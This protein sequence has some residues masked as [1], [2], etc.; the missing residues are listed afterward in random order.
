MRGL[1]IHIP[2]CKHICLYCD[3]RKTV[4]LKREIM[5]KYIKYL[6]N[7][8][9]SYKDKYKDCNTIYIG[10]GTPNA[11]PLDLLKSLFNTIDIFKEKLN[12]KEY[13]IEINPELL[14]IDQVNLFKKHNIT[15]V[16]IGAESFNDEILKKLGRHHCKEDIFNSVNLLKS[17]GINNINVDLIFAHP[18]DNLDLVKENLN[19]F[20]LLDIPH[21][22]YYSMI[23][24]DK[25][26]F[27]YQYD[28]NEIEMPSEDLSADLF[29]FIINDL[30]DHN[31]KQYEISNFSKEGFESI[32][33]EIYWKDLEYIGCGLNASGYLDNIRYTNSPN[34]KEYYLGKKETEVIDEETNRNEYMMLGLRMVKGVSINEYHQRFNR[35][36]LDDYSLDKFINDGLLEKVDGYIRFTRKG[37]ML[38][39][40][41]FMEFV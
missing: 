3:F 39:D 6:N 4:T 27:K 12:I 18:F 20:Y 37:L 13:S 21:I 14:N 25:T 23:L 8:I 35:N 9:L 1:Y 17:E 22:S 7:E 34:F 36:M 30:E 32:H 26:V 2:F 38:G 24:E 19:N 5:E 40:I 16:S 10:G 31:Y 33:N 41:V 29:E 28:R 11:L 15:R